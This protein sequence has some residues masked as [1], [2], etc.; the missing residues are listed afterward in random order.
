MIFKS[1]SF[2]V[3]VT[4]LTLLNTASAAYISQGVN[5]VDR[6]YAEGAPAGIIFN[7]QGAATT[8]I[9]P[10]IYIWN[11]GQT[12]PDDWHIRWT[13]Y[14]LSGGYLFDGLVQ[15]ELGNSVLSTSFVSK[16]SGNPQDW[17]VSQ[18]TPNR[19]YIIFS[20]YVNQGWDGID[21]SL[22]PNSD[23]S[24]IRLSLGST[25][26][27]GGNNS[28]SLESGWAEATNI[29]LGSSLNTIDANHAWNLYTGNASFDIS[30]PEP[31]LLSLFGLGLVGL[32]FSRKWVKK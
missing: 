25:L 21:F 1:F 3:L 8:A 26:F 4:T 10:G 28:S 20:S 30:V 11:D 32:G 31:A 5:P 9:S 12:N 17:V 18:N 24:V 2:V 19:D 13:D 14:P 22:D 27:A 6:T 15:V 23:A 29:F 7:N 16:D